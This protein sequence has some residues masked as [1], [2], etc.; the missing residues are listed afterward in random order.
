MKSQL[1]TCPI[2]FQNVLSCFRTTQTPHPTPPNRSNIKH[3]DRELELTLSLVTLICQTGTLAEVIM[4]LTI[5]RLCFIKPWTLYVCHAMVALDS[6]HISIYTTLSI[7]L[8]KKLTVMAQLYTRGRTFLLNFEQSSSKTERHT[9]KKSTLDK[10]AF[11]Q[12]LV[13]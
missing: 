10:V 8:G 4:N 12:D 13:W 3:Q 11:F 7:F 2:L 6:V 5:Y 9:S 1:L